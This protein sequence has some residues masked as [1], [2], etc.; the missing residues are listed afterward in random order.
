MNDSRSDKETFFSYP[1]WDRTVRIFHWVNVLCIIGLSGLG[2]MLLYNKDFGVSSDGKVLLKTLHA[3]IGYVFALNLT[4]RLIW[5]FIGNQYSRWRAILPFGKGYLNSLISYLKGFKGGSGPHYAGHNPAA[6]LMVTL[7]FLLL[8]TQ[9]T[10][11]LVLAGTDLYLPPFG[12]EIAE[13]VSASDETHGGLTDLKP[14]SKVGVDP[15]SYR[16]MRTFRKPFITAHEYGFYLLAIFILLH[17]IA[18]V[19]TEI[20]EKSALVSA[21]FNGKKVFKQDPVDLEDR[22]QS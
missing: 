7:L 22:E 10:S 11:G 20:R 6:R 3:Y 14:G 12:H 2:L 19:V 13:W 4:W 8:F 17:I 21:M 18:V 9:G 1:V 5:G 16:E 15:D